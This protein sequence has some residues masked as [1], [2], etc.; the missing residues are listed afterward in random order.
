MKNRQQVIDEPRFARVSARASTVTPWGR[1]ES[2][3]AREN[4]AQAER[5]AANRLERRRARAALREE[6]ER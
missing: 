6:V 1:Y 3:S 5:H 4:L 2:H